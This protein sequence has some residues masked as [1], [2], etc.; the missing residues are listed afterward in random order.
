[1]TDAELPPQPE[2][3]ITSPNSKAQ[4]LYQV[5]FERALKRISGYNKSYFISYCLKH[6]ATLSNENNQSFNFEFV[7]ILVIKLSATSK[8]GKRR[9]GKNEIISIINSLWGV[10]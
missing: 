5:R 6:I 9:P 10:Q 3:F 1:M 7:W 2:L 8:G 4:A